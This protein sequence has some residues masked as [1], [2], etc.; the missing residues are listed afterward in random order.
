[1]KTLI[2]SKGVYFTPQVQYK[3]KA[4]A[5]TYHVTLKNLVPAL[6]WYIANSDKRYF[7]S[8]LSGGT[9]KLK[10]VDISDDV[11]DCLKIQACKH[12]LPFNHYINMAL[13]DTFDEPY[14]DDTCEELVK[15]FY[16]DII[17]CYQDSLTNA[18]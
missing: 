8:S 3:L 17:K 11:F 15:K 2:S 10:H 13:L 1:M 5:C 12:H 16:D 14:E 7:E 9:F 6:L 18:S 4:I